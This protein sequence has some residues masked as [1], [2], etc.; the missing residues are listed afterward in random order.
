MMKIEIVGIALV[1]LVSLGVLAQGKMGGE[2]TYKYGAH[3]EK[4]S[5]GMECLAT[6]AEMDD[7]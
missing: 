2:L 5:D 4:Y 6:E 3:V 1:A 7:E